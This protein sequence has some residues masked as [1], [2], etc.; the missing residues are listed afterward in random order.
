MG[1]VAVSPYWLY[2]LIRRREME[3]RGVHVGCHRCFKTNVGD[4]EWDVLS[5]SSSL[6]HLR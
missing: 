4:V 3:L 2:C 5:F 1:K 6:T